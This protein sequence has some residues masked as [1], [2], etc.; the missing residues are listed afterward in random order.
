MKIFFDF[1]G[2]HDSDINQKIVLAL[3]EHSS[4]VF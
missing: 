1:V 3:S 2:N 4:F